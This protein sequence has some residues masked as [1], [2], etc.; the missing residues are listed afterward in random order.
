MAI[1]PAVSG[2]GSWPAFYTDDP[3]IASEDGERHR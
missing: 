3:A 2:H 1:N